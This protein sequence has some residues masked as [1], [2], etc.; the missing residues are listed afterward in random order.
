MGE[1]GE[2]R[3]NAL[4]GRSGEEFNYVESVRAREREREREREKRTKIK[5]NNKII[6][7]KATVTM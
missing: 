1:M 5:D 6:R 4:R 3:W 2:L 7:Q